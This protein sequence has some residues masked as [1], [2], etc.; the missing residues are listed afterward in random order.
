MQVD[1]KNLV[2]I[3]TMALSALVT[4]LLDA[5]YILGYRS[6]RNAEGKTNPKLENSSK[7]AY[8]FISGTGLNIMIDYYHL[9]YDPEEIRNKFNGLFKVPS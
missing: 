1:Y 8:A 9:D 5:A 3:T 2:F 4:T 6:K 7:E